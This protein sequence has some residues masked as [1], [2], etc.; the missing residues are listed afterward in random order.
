MKHLTNIDK[1]RL[2]KR[3]VI[4]PLSDEKVRKIEEELDKYAMKGYDAEE[5]RPFYDRCKEYH[6]LNNTG[7]FQIS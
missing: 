6:I 3:L 2:E 1:V 7:Y 5:L 4:E